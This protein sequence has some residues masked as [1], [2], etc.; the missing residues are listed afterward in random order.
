MKRILISLSLIALI[1][2]VSLA[3]TTQEGEKK[4]C[5]KGK[6]ECKDKDKKDCKDADK[7]EC[8]KGEK[9]SCCKGKKECKKDS[10]VTK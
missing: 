9:K 3:G 7:K 6:K 10:T 4:S 2:S 8:K 1:A 5:C